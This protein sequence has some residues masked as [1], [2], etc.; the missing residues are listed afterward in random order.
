MLCEGEG[1][2]GCMGLVNDALTKD[3]IRGYRGNLWPVFGVR[4][5][6]NCDSGFTHYL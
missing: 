5:T 4:F 2:E 6:K 3:G 1:E